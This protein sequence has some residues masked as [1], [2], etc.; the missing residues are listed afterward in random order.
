MGVSGPQR[1][2][3][4]KNSEGE[5]TWGVTQIKK[6]ININSFFRGR[7]DEGRSGGWGGG[8]ELPRRPP[9]LLVLFFIFSYS[10]FLV[11][12]PGL[13]TLIFRFC[14]SLSLFFYALS[15]FRTFLHANIF[16]SQASC[17]R[18]ESS[19]RSNTKLTF[20]AFSTV[21]TVIRMHK[22]N[23]TIMAYAWEQCIISWVII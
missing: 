2:G 10:I 17:L 13:S 3:G 19:A 4:R 15:F 23:W 9:A 22:G 5:K 18:T 16:P 11:C 12:F 21:S 7:W 20:A 8:A 14:H 1:N 6:R